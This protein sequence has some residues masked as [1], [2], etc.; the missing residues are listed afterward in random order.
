[1]RR[2]LA[3]IEHV[4]SIVMLTDSAVTVHNGSRYVTVVGENFL[5]REICEGRL[6]VEGKIQKVEFFIA[7]GSKSASKAFRSASCWMPPQEAACCS[8]LFA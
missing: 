8:K 3:T 7:T 4:Q 1:M 2:G 5:I 6:T